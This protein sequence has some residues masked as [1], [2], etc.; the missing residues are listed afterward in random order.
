M[1]RRTLFQRPLQITL[2]ATLAVFTVV[3]YFNNFILFWIQLGI[4]LALVIATILCNIFA[5]RRMYRLVQSVTQTLKADDTD[6]IKDYPMP[7]VVVNDK[8]EIVWYDDCFRKEVVADNDIYGESAKEEFP[9]LKFW[10]EDFTSGTADIEYNGKKYTVYGVKVASNNEKKYILYFAENTELKKYYNEY[11]ETRPSIV[12]FVVDNYEELLQNATDSEKSQIMGEIEYLVEKFVTQTNGFVK[13]YERDKMIAVI[14]ERYIKK[15]ID[16]KFDILD[17]VRSI[18]ADGRIQ[19]TLSIGVGR[20]ASNLEES[21]HLA[22]QA[23]D[24]CLGRGGDQAA[25]K[26]ANGFDFYGGVSK[27]VEKRTKVKARI[28][29]SAITELINNAD[30]VVVMGHS[31]GDLD[32]IGAAVGMAQAA[33]HLGKMSYVAVNESRCLAV[34]LIN[35]LRDRGVNDLFYTPAEVLQVITKKTLLIIVDT[36]IKH[37]VESPDIYKDCRTVVV[38]DHHRK[39]VD[40]IDNAVIFYHEPY[41]S[42]ASE[43]VTELVQYMHD[44]KTIGKNEAE[45]LLA[46]IMLDT[47]NFVLKTGVRTFE[48]AAY[49]RRLGADT[50]ESRRLFSNSMESYQ[51]KTRL[52]SSAEVYRNCAVVVNEENVTND[53]EMRIVAAQAADELLGINDVD[54]SFVLFES[55]NKVSV[56]GRSMGAVNVQIILEQMGG[57][58]HLT[59]AGAQVESESIEDVKQQL[60]EAIDK[61]YEDI[62]PA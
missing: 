8:C 10:A 32:S 28:I 24:M 25:V 34:P 1:N 37:F 31:F 52:V 4:T 26:T 53:E 17:K 13:K 3:M 41:A 38:I 49:L 20:G 44:R 35:M 16:N 51:K 27:A 58:G 29:A 48:A 18:V 30:N 14:E 36:H 46:G 11:F 50:V 40:H 21:E 60:L 56:S 33:R 39:S 55:G 5:N 12:L 6:L 43:M 23:L 19:A 61:Y 54:A 42:S 45:S 62:K 9:A 57:G 2:L 22:R 47:K 59:M 7:V 15:I